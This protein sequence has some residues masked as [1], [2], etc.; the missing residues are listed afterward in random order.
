MCLS[1]RRQSFSQLVRELKSDI[2]NPMYEGSF[3]RK[4]FLVPGFKYTFHHRICFYMRGV[5][6]LRPLCFLHLIYLSHL[7][8]KYGIEMSSRFHIPERLS[9]AHFGGIV[10]YPES[11]GKNVLVRQGVTVGNNGKSMKG[12]SIGNNVSFGAHSMALGDITIGD[13]TVIAAGAVVTKDV[14]SVATVAGVP[15]KVISRSGL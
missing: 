13:N 14:P 7:R 10:F 2:R 1:E 6:W 11:C 12:P 9:I 4:L 8:I 15:A 5:W 3:A